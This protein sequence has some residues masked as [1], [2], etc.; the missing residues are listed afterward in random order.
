MKIKRWFSRV[1]RGWVP[2]EP[3]TSKHWLKNKTRLLGLSVR[4]ASM[5]TIGVLSL[6]SS[7]L[8]AIPP[9]IFIG[10][11]DPGVSIGDYVTY[12][13]FVCNVGHPSGHF[14]INDLAFKKMEVIAISGKEVTFLYTDQ[15]KN[16][17]A[18]LR[19][20]LTS[21][22]NV[23]TFA[24]GADDDELWIDFEQIIAANLTDGSCILNCSESGNSGWSRDHSLGTEVRTYLGCDRNV[25]IHSWLFAD[26]VYP[27]ETRCM[28]Y[29]VYDQLS[30]IRLET[31]KFAWDG[32]GYGDL[33]QGFSVVETN[34][35]SNSNSSLSSLQNTM[36]KIPT[37]AIY[38]LTGL[39]IIATF[40]T[41]GVILRKRRFRGGEK[42]AEE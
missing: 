25:V 37:V 34:I 7:P 11:Y 5:V 3:Q 10:E 21:T 30:G 41:I 38:A 4:V 9:P 15:F 42:D 18:T 17:S 36:A 39:I 13:N 32:T 19:N 35:L 20:G 22:W 26:G 1:L 6:V 40:M 31:K 2:A 27:S 12:G 28:A 8:T 29:T 23:E 16:G 33:L 24:W 14:C